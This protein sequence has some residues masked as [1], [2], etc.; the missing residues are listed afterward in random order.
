MTLKTF[1]ETFE[2]VSLYVDEYVRDSS[3]YIGLY[4]DEGP[5]ADLTVCLSDPGLREN[6]S[7][8]DINNLPEAMKFIE[9]NNLGTLTGFRP[10]G[11]V[12]YPKV[13]F[14]MA[15]VMRHVRKEE[16]HEETD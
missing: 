9:D 10:S 11:W 3:I 12:T 14:N 16:E 7:Y 5:I 13:E 1:F 4:N 15:E 6:E 2:N 8:V